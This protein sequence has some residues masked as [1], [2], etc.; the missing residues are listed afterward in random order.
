MKAAIAVAGLAA[1]LAAANAHLPKHGHA[2]AHVRRDL[3][4]TTEWTTVT[5]VDTVT[6]SPGVPAPSDNAYAAPSGAQ[7]AAAS[8]AGAGGVEAEAVP[9]SSSTS[10]QAAVS[11]PPVQGKAAV[12]NQPA[13]GNAPNYN[14]PSNNA[15]SYNAP[16]P[17]TT[18]ATTTA[19]PAG[20]NANGIAAPAITNPAECPLSPP[21]VYKSCADAAQGYI[22]SMQKASDNAYQSSMDS[23][24]G[25]AGRD[26]GA[27]SV[28]A[29]VT[30]P[31]QPGAPV[32]APTGKAVPDANGC[33]DTVMTYYYPN[34]GLG[35]CG[36]PIDNGEPAVAIGD[37]MLHCSK[38]N[39]QSMDIWVN[40]SSTPVEVKVKDKCGACESDG[41]VDAAGDWAFT[42][43]PGIGKP[44]NVTIRYCLK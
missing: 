11:I 2:N 38:N 31:S 14:A 13:Q 39:F 12:N 28:A 20:S 26:P 22:N 35:S 41:H 16:A 19:A 34:N 4:Y 21:E 29:T 33:A 30:A 9:T 44:G 3:A 27:S 18:L 15:P 24:Q 43:A 7:G 10:S 6:L 1:T 40:G 42:V 8:Q 25:T 17:A 32:P 5:D 23:Q 36:N 37:F